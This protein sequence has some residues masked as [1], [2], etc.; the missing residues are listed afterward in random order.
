MTFPIT[1]VGDIKPYPFAYTNNINPV[2]QTNQG[3]LK[4]AILR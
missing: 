2:N 3:T 4:G 1:L